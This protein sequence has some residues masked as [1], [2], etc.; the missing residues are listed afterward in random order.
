[1][2]NKL[3]PETNPVIK[4]L[5]A[6]EVRTIMATGDN[7]L[8]AISVARQ[9][10]IL[11]STHEVFL[12]EVAQNQ[13]GV[14]YVKWTSSLPASHSITATNASHDSPELY[15]EAL[16]RR[17]SSVGTQNELQDLNALPDAESSDY[18][19]WHYKND[20]VGVGI[21]GKAFKILASRKE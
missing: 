17:Q 15:E 11:D 1:M 19:P 10:G 12:G 9:C 2:E 13:Q 14:E 4:T 3:K 21:T 16:H 18:I 5:Q 8:T 7:V 20:E 6:C